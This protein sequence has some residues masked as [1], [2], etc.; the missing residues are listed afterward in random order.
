MKRRIILEEYRGKDGSSKEGK[1]K[2]D[3]VLSERREAR[4]SDV[5]IQ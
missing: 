4:I 1:E 2:R 3:G 5:K